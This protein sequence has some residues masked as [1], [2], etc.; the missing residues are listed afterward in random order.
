MNSACVTLLLALGLCLN[1]LNALAEVTT[2]H[3]GHTRV[4]AEVARTPQNHERGL[5]F[6]KQLCANCGMLFVF[7]KAGRLSFW[8]KN[9]LIPLSVAFISADG[10]IL[11][12][13][14]MQPDTTVKHFAHGNALYAL[15]M[16]RDW[17]AEM[18]IAPGHKITD[19]DIVLAR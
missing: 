6:R 17:F 7:P 16:H 2:L 10:T 12:I 8:M 13:E 9:T 11:N 5:M 15:E 19:L 4:H 3:I 18:G 14:Q 1:P